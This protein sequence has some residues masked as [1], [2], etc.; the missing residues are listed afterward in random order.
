[1]GKMYEKGAILKQHL[2][3]GAPVLIAFYEMI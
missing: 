2:G 1:M 3:Y